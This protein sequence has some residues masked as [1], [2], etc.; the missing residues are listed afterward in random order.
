M[1][2]VVE[3]LLSEKP[4]AAV[5][6]ITDHFRAHATSMC[7]SR[8]A[9]V[10]LDAVARTGRADVMDKLWSSFQQDLSINS[11]AKFARLAWVD[12]HAPV[13]SLWS[14]R[15]SPRYLQRV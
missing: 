1:Y 15:S 12:M 13:T 7:N 9:T 10:A 6:E 4:D 5:E 2:E 14:T 11:T 3:A 8:A